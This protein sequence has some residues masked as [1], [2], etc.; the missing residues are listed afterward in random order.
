MFGRGYLGPRLSSGA[1]L[2]LLPPLIH[3]H[4]LPAPANLAVCMSAKALLIKGI[5]RAFFIRSWL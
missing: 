5:S 1:A 3:Q 4:L 2:G